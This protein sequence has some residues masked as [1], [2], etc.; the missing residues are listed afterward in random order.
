MACVRP[1]FDLRMRDRVDSTP[2]SQV[3][4]AVPCRFEFTTGRLVLADLFPS[5]IQVSVVVS[6]ARVWRWLCLWLN[7]GAVRVR[8][9][10]KY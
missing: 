7:Q 1:P 5:V 8:L 2:F 4:G 9:G 3:D 6:W 10:R